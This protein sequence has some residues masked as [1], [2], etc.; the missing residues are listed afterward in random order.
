MIV[1]HQSYAMRHSLRDEA[2]NLV[3]PIFRRLIAGYDN[4][5]QEALPPSRGSIEQVYR[6]AV[7]PSNGFC[8]L[9]AYVGRSGRVA[10]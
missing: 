7:E 9:T 5:N 3:E 1:P 8:I 4:E 10:T 6:F 2:F